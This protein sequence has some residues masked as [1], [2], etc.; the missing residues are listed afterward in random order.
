VFLRLSE[1][2]NESCFS[3]SKGADTAAS[4]VEAFLDV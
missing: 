4:G 1:L 2:M 3:F